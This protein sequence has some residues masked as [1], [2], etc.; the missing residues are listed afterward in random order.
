MNSLEAVPPQEAGGTAA[1]PWEKLRQK[2]RSD[3]EVAEQAAQPAFEHLGIMKR[4]CFF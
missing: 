4:R 3:L 2:V 1:F